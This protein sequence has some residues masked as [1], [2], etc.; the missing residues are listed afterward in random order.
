MNKKPPNTKTKNTEE[1]KYKSTEPDIKIP[2]SSIERDQ[3]DL[4]FVSKKDHDKLKEELGTQRKILTWT[5]AFIIAILI[6]CFLTF[7]V[8]V[9]DA[10]RFHS[11]NY[12]VLVSK[13]EQLEQN[14]SDKIYQQ[15]VTRIRFL[16]ENLHL[17]FNINSSQATT[18]LDSFNRTCIDSTKQ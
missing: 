3:G 1:K 15:L 11:K 5:Q 7:V 17:S 9:V 13:I 14:Y 2:E 6:T 4:Y 10:W 8:L 12:Q 16:E 18:E